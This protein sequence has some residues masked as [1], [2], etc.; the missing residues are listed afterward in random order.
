MLRGRSFLV[1]LITAGFV[2]RSEASRRVIDSNA[3]S[4]IA[5]AI[6]A[7][8]RP[9]GWTRYAGPCLRMIKELAESLQDRRSA[10]N[11]PRHCTHLSS[12]NAESM[13]RHIAHA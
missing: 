9:V 11:G 7:V 12:K 10:H 8:G 3:C 4:P 5:I 2:I 6:L 1:V 13:I